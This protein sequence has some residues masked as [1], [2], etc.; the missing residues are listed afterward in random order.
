MHTLFVKISVYLG[1]FIINKIDE[2]CVH[3]KVK[4]GLDSLKYTQCP[5]LVGLASD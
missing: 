4:Q 5:V 1:K 3:R 2:K